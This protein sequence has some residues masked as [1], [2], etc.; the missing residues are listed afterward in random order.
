VP[1]RRAPIAAA[2]RATELGL[3]AYN[4]LEGFEGDP[5][6]NG[7]RQKGRLAFSRPALAAGLIARPEA[8]PLQG[9]AL[10]HGPK[11]K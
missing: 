3:T 6:D 11:M 5:D 10:W 2:K 9:L 7:Q 4:I 8:A 1:Q